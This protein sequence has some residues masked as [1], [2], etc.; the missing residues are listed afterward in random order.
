VPAA[1]QAWQIPAVFLRSPHAS[2][3]S[4]RSLP[5]AREP[6]WVIA[7]P[8]A[9]HETGG[10]RQSHDRRGGVGRSDSSTLIPPA[11]GGESVRQ[12]G[13][14]GAVVIVET[15]LTAR[16]AV[17]PVVVDYD[18]REAVTNLGRSTRAPSEHLV[19]PPSRS[20]RDRHQTSSLARATSNNSLQENRQQMWGAAGRDAPLVDRG[21]YPAASPTWAGVACRH[22]SL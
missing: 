18:Q 2:S 11:L 21:S 3:W 20:P 1:L 19:P 6:P 5:R 8:S 15:E 22:R 13:E 4:G 12:I 17:E 9:Q 16:D 10:H 14:T 7:A